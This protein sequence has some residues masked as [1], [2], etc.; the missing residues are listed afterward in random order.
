MVVGLGH[1]KKDRFKDLTPGEWVDRAT[2][3]D[4][5]SVDARKI[6]QWRDD[7]L[8]TCWV[9]SKRLVRFD[10]L[11]VDEELSCYDVLPKRAKP[12]SLG[13][14]GSGHEPEIESPIS[15]PCPTGP[16][17]RVW[18]KKER[19]AAALNVCPRIINYWMAQERIPYRQIP[20]TQL[21]Y[22]LDD[23]KMALRPFL[24]PAARRGR[25][26]TGASP[27]DGSEDDK[28]DRRRP[29][30]L[31][32]HERRADTPSP[33]PREIREEGS[34]NPGNTKIP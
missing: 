5:Y 4:L 17:I 21:L 20:G 18:I 15:T 23:V 14:G 13:N 11:I 1:A 24:I 19:L 27:G 10:P 8:I 30:P 22:N 31:P 32:P 28:G 16:R 9:P 33:G 26:Q 25:I 12:N 34:E 29:S 3:A 7:G 6:D 2:L